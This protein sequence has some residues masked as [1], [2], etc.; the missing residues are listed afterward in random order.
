ME[1]LLNSRVS[2]SSDSL[3]TRTAA[4]AALRHQRFGG[5]DHLIAAL[6]GHFQRPRRARRV[7]HKQLVMDLQ[8]IRPGAKRHFSGDSA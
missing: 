6:A 4:G 1:M 2:G 3:V 5:L 8:S 7:A